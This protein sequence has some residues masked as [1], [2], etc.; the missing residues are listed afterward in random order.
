MGSSLVDAQ[1]TLRLYDITQYFKHRGVVDEERTALMSV[2]GVIQ[3]QNYII[4]A[5]SGNGKTFLTNVTLS[6]LPEDRIYTWGLD[7]D[8][9][10]FEA[11]EHLDDVWVIFITELQKFMGSN[12][13][14]KTEMLKDLGE[15][16]NPGT[17]RRKMGK[18]TSEGQE[19]TEQNIT[20][21]K[22][23]I[24]TL[25]VEN[26]SYK[27]ND[28]EL[29]RRYPTFSLDVSPEH[30]KR[31][32][33]R[34]MELEFKPKRLDIL[35]DSRI[36]AVKARVCGALQEDLTIHNPVAVGIEP[37]I[38][39]VDVQ[40]PSFVNHFRHFMRATTRFYSWRAYQPTKGEY[41][42]TVADLWELWQIYG[43][44][45]W[46]T[47]NKVPFLGKRIIAALQSADGTTGG[48]TTLA[49]YGGGT[50]EKR[51][52]LRAIHR[53]LA[54]MKLPL[55][56]RVLSPLVNKMCDASFLERHDVSKTERLFS[57]AEEIKPLD[58]VDWKQ[59]LKTSMKLIE[60]VDGLE[61]AKD[62]RD[63]QLDNKGHLYVDHPITGKTIKVM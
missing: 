55:P 46:M 19:M 4:E 42:T 51:V 45:L 13:L 30:V 20:G 14:I 41:W 57:L 40:T 1:D 18:F 53:Q 43:D 56:Y 23:I 35:S 48:A 15:D 58:K 37:Y 60:S 31:I 22:A 2:L 3:K 39:I 25:A 52:S 24:S 21:D 26:Q 8:A 5:L 50:S 34:Q 61:V 10:A 49:E 63:W 36:A 7:T 38:P 47:V 12:S 54:K 28:V 6:L 62:W 9:A 59:V 27:G 32:V 44:M 11:S 29:G 16:E 17:R 33:S